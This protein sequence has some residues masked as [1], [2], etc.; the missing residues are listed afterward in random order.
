MLCAHRPGEVWQGRRCAF[1]LVLRG[2]L[3]ASGRLHERL[4]FV[5]VAAATVWAF[6]LLTLV[7]LG[8]SGGLALQAWLH[9][10]GSCGGWV[11]FLRG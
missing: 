4:G 3:V 11:A 6:W 10:W 5:I 8:L 9:G 7:G 1:I 2:G